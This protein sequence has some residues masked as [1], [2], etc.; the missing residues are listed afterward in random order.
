MLGKT[1]ES[2]SGGKL[3]LKARGSGSRPLKLILDL[4]LH[5]W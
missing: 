3:Q 5:W 2:Q 4:G 1:R